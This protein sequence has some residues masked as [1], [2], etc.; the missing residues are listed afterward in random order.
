MPTLADIA[1]ALDV[2]APAAP[3]AARNVRGVATVEEAGEDDITFVSS[4]AFAKP[5][6]SSRA[7]AVIAQKGVTIAPGLGGVVFTVEDADLAVA[8]VLGLFAPPIPRPFVGVDAQAKV[9]RTATMGEA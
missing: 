2:P 8:K 3:H 4:E 9:S 7:L 6:A 1:A 5:L